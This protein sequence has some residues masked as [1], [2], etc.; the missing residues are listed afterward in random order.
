MA[1][2]HYV[3]EYDT[4]KSRWDWSPQVEEQVFNH[5]TILSV[6]GEW[7]PDDVDTKGQMKPDIDIGERLSLGLRFLNYYDERYGTANVAEKSE[8]K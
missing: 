2:H 7:L 8:S 6:V 1:K 4:I 3:I 5:K